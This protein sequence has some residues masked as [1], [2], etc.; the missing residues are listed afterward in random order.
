MLLSPR[1]QI[2]HIFTHHETPHLSHKKDETEI[3][4]PSSPGPPESNDP[5]LQPL[6]A[7]ESTRS[8]SDKEQ[9][10][11][12]VQKVWNG[13]QSVLNPPMI[14]GLTAVIFGV[15]PFL[16]NLI[17]VKDAPLSTIFDSINILG[18]LYTGLQAFVLGGQLYSKR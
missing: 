13:I 1:A 5:E 3:A 12:T 16:R 18:K 6:L 17:L 8:Q 2:D 14:G 4:N 7:E 11:S 9:T 10:K 15:I